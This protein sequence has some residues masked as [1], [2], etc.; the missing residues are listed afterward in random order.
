MITKIIRCLGIFI[1]IAFSVISILFSMAEREIDDPY[2]KKIFSY[3]SYFEDRFY[4][5]RMKQTLDPDMVDERIVLAKIDD[6]ALKRIGRWPWSRTVWAE[7][8]NKMKIFEAKVL[9]FDVFFSEPEK[10]CN[11]E[12]PDK[13]MARAIV[14]F[15]T[16]PGNKVIIPYSLNNIDIEAFKEIPDVLYNFIVDTKQADGLNLRESVVSKSVFPIPLFT[17]IEAGL[18]HIEAE[19]DADG[20]FRHYPIISNVETLY[21]P[22][23]SL[24]A[25]QLYTG[26]K[27]VME[28]L[29]MDDYNL[30]TKQG[31]LKLNYKGETKVRWIG[32]FEHFPQVSIADILEANENDPEMHK[33]F[34]GTA[35]FIGSTA[36]GAHDLRHTP[37]DAMLPGVFLHMNA[38]NMLLDGNYFKSK[39][40]STYI[41]WIV[42]LCATFLMIIIQLF[43]N[44]L[45]DLLFASVMTFG[46]LFFDTFYL[47]PAGY[48]I[49]LFFCLFSIL[50][51]YSWTT[52]LNFYLTSK[53]KKFLK[54]AFGSYISPELIDEMYKSGEPPKLGGEVGIL[55]AYFTDIQGFSTFSEK[56]TAPQ[57]VELLN[58]Y[59]TEMTDILLHDSG[60]LDKYEGDAIIAFFGAPMPLEDHAVR[61]CR[62]AV[63]MQNALD[64]L[65][66]KWTNE[67]DRWP[68]FVR[69]MRMRIGINSGEIVTGNMGSRDRMN[70]TMMGDSVNL[71]AR[72]EEA[73]K[74]YGIFT[75]ISEYTKELTGDHFEM[76]EL[77]TIK[78]MGKSKPVTT[79]D[80]LGEIGKINDNLIKLK[81]TFHQGLDKYKNQEWDEAMT[82]FQESLECEHIRYPELIEKKK[83][84]SLIYIERCKNFKENPPPIDWDG[85]YTLT[86]K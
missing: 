85:V 73:A 24:L 5:M 17:N 25:Y 62:T 75:Q 59:L 49:K 82:L 83:N 6:N 18:G 52:F 80:L 19:E 50:A 57:L 70:Y 3:P 61:A 15:Q 20:I 67:G 16:V 9:A 56:L 71:A 27:P 81:E 30:K 44:A 14:D 63:H 4:D 66:I 33:I 84:P 22:S 26:D 45:L 46:L 2:V 68:I 69:E 60:T 51:C 40:E 13:I 76:R 35:V 55:T 74:Q 72:L 7:F 53:D 39:H 38:L 11:Q 79:F 43:G 1:I 37:I 86:S 34:K 28:M 21:F 42:L 48:E 8:I 36:F 65:R 47:T 77:D 54:N 12:S 31:I 78:V 41:S 10:A 64:G 23:F 29:A 32:G 58:E